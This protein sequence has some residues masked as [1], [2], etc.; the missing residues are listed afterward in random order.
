MSGVNQVT[1]IGYMGADPEVRFTKSG[2]AVCTF[3]LACTTSYYNATTKQRVENTEWVTCTAWNAAEWIG[4]TAHKGSLVHV[5]GSLQTRTWETKSGEKRYATEV[6]CEQVN[7]LSRYGDQSDAKQSG[8][9]SQEQS[10]QPDPG[11]DDIPF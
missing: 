11:D 4:K 10:Q 5:F 8:G 9:K 2:K 6:K 7:L 1:L 3:R